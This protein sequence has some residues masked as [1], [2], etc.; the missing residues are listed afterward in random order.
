MKKVMLI[1]A[2]AM[3]FSLPAAAQKKNQV[4]EKV[5]V[6]F[7]EKFPEAKKVKW[8][9]EENGLWEAEF[10]QDKKEYS[11]SY[12]ANGEWMETEYEIK[13]S[14]I[15]KEIRLILDQHFT[16]YEIDEAELVETAAGKSYEFEMEIG[17]LEYEVKIDAQGNVTKE[18]HTKKSEKHED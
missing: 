3:V 4:P 13:E 6:A 9:Q 11:A 17:E 15:P 18:I 7:L 14:E 10:K 12:K 1:A 2:V 16:N 8:E 5:Q